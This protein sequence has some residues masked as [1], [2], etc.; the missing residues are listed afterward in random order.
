M[1]TRACARRRRLRRRVGLRL[2]LLL[3]PVL[4]W[5]AVF[6]AI[7]GLGPMERAAGHAPDAARVVIPAT[8]LLLA[9]LLGLPYIRDR[10]W[11]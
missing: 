8:C 7:A 4:F 5:S 3:I 9:A 11:S 6:T 1:R 10:G 2:G